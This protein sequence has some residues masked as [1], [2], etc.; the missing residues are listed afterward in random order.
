MKTAVINEDINEIISEFNLDLRK[1]EGKTILITG[2]NGLIP[3]Y[4][5]D[6][7]S[8]LNKD[9]EK[10]IKIIVMNKNPTTVDSRLGH[11]LND[12]N[13]LFVTQDVGKPFDV[14]GKPD[15]II[16]AASRAN[17][18]AFLEDPIDTIDA[19][20]NATKRLLDYAKSN[21]VDNF[22]FFS[23][24]EIY[25]NATKEFI[26][27]PETYAGNTGPLD[28]YSCYSE[29]KR[30][31][32]TLC[33]NYFNRFGIPTKILRIG[34]TYGPGIRNDGK[35]VSDFFERGMK[36]KVITLRDAGEAK[37]SFCYV[38]DCA[39]GIFKIMFYGLNGE[40]YNLGSDTLP[41]N[42]TIKKLAELIAQTIGPDVIVKPNFDAPKRQ[43]YGE[44][45]R[46]LKIDKLRKLD[47]EPR[48]MIKEGLKRT[49]RDYDE[50]RIYSR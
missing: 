1:L 49:K 15:V 9:L 36:E 5:V 2:G 50:K 45:N 38:S 27:T 39:R 10:P 6:V 24:G 30:F 43:I 23:S 35:A 41:E 29:S 21:K 17:P 18:T 34:M 20:V 13:V 28:K 47:F 7:F 25:G 33:Y 26:P 42:I 3:S 14:L 40:A 32:E 44:D 16:H 8:S 11:L 31:C 46:W 22:L 19:N 37:R 4:L 48:V 12:K